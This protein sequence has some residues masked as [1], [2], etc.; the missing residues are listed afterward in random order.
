MS[1]SRAREC[2]LKMLIS[3]A[4][5]CNFGVHSLRSGGVTA[6]ANNEVGDR[7]LKRHGRWKRDES[8]DGYI[9]DSI[10]KRLHVTKSLGL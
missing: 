6:A 7:C 3:V 5:N 10:E 4:P 1:Y 8:K 9:E 2:I